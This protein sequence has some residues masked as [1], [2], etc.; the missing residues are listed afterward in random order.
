MYAVD[1]LPTS[2]E[3]NSSYDPS[4]DLEDVVVHDPYG[5]LGPNPNLRLENERANARQPLDDHISPIK[6]HRERN[7]SSR[8]DARSGD[9]SIVSWYKLC[10]CLHNFLRAVTIIL[11]VYQ[12]RVSESLNILFNAMDRFLLIRFRLCE[13]PFNIQSGL[14][15]I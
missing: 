2:S 15:T 1:F 12:F 8:R 6:G 11:D 7:R 3:S 5:E 14:W 9:P 4:E 13:A 10:L